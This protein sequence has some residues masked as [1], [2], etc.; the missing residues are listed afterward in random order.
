MQWIYKHSTLFF[1]TNALVLLLIILFLIIGTNQLGNFNL[2]NWDMLKF[3]WLPTLIYC[4]IDLVF[5]SLCLMKR[6]FVFPLILL[7]A[8]TDL[9]HAIANLLQVLKQ[10][11]IYPIDNIWGIIAII[12]F[13][14]AATGTLMWF[15]NIRYYGKK[16]WH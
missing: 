16:W 5:M 2:H 12:G 9:N 3:L 8:L 7:H 15:K 10:G 1:Y 13:I 11:F 6:Y 14:L 4:V